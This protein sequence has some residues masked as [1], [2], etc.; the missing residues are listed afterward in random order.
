MAVAAAEADRPGATRGR[1][2]CGSPLIG[3]RGARGELGGRR[4]R[5]RAAVGAA[6]AVFHGSPKPANL[7]K[8]VVAGPGDPFGRSGVAQGE[9]PAPHGGHAAAGGERQAEGARRHLARPGLAASRRGHAVAPNGPVGLLVR[10]LERRRPSWPAAFHQDSDRFD[11]WCGFL[12]AFRPRGAV[13]LQLLAA[14]L[15]RGGRYHPRWRERCP[16]GGKTHVARAQQKERRTQLLPVHVLLPKSTCVDLLFLRVGH[17][18]FGRRHHVAVGFIAAHRGAVC[19]LCLH[20]FHR[21]VPYRLARPRSLAGHP[22]LGVL[23]RR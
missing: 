19:H 12:R 16:S 11:H 6:R 9:C 14:R 3:E 20:R 10:S 1:F 22:D 4:A 21:C 15:V 18:W 7:G 2:R 13:L 23:H 8:F 17:H 5:P